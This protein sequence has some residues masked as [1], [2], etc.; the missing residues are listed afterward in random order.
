MVLSNPSVKG[1]VSRQMCLQAP[2][3]IPLAPERQGHQ[4]RWGALRQIVVFEPSTIDIISCTC[5]VSG[6]FGCS[7]S[8]WIIRQTTEFCGNQCRKAVMG[9]DDIPPTTF[10]KEIAWPCLQQDLEMRYSCQGLTDTFWKPC[11]NKYPAL[12]LRLCPWIIRER[13]LRAVEADEQPPDHPHCLL[14]PWKSGKRREISV[15]HWEGCQLLGIPALTTSETW[16]PA[17]WA[18]SP[19]P[20]HKPCGKPAETQLGCYHECAEQAELRYQAKIGLG[21]LG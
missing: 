21:A 6:T 13:C 20:C 5:V 16:G 15:S 4:R 1:L 17:A 12:A 7:L 2:P 10:S 3:W 11:L 19:F 9:R 8:K 14:H 18:A